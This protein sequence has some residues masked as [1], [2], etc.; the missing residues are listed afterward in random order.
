MF[1]LRYTRDHKSVRKSEDLED[2][3]GTA[4]RS[5][6]LM[7]IF[8]LGTKEMV[9]QSHRSQT[10]G[11]KNLRGLVSEVV[12]DNVQTLTFANGSIRQYFV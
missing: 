3:V 5:D 11:A 9:Y 6:F 10:F 8:D 2:L 1:D 12:V 7:Y 4:E